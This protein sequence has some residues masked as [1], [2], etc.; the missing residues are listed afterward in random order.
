[1]SK[2]T[3]TDEQQAIIQ[4][5]KLSD[6]LLCN[7]YAGAAKTSTLEMAAPQIRVP[8][9]ALA[10]NKKNAQTMKGRL[11]SNFQTLTMNGLGQMAWARALPAHVALKLDERKLGK[12][13]TALAHDQHIELSETQW[14][15]V[16]V[17]VTLAMLEGIVPGDEGQPLV[18]D[19]PEVWQQL[20]ARAYATSDDSQ[21]LCDLARS[22]LAED[23]RLARQGHISFD[24]QVYCPTMLGGKWPRFPAAIVDEFQDLSRLN[25]RMLELSVRPDA[26]LLIVGDE[27]QSLYAFRG[28]SGQAKQLAHALRPHEWLELPLSMTFRCPKAIVARQQLHAPGFRAHETNRQGRHVVLGHNVDALGWTWK[29]LRGLREGSVAILCRNNAPLLRL[30]LQLIRQQVAPMMLGRDIGKGLA[31]LAK[32]IIPRGASGQDAL[33]GAVHEWKDKE[34]AAAE[35]EPQVD[36]ITDRAE[37]LLAVIEGSAARSQREIMNALDLLF[38]NTDGDVTLATIHRAKGLEWDVVLHLDPWRIPARAAREAH[39]RGDPVQMQQELNARYVCE[40]RTRDVLVEA[41]AEGF[42]PGALT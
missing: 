42:M 33:L 38:S 4:A 10:F 23:I 37:C 40:T 5:A 3:P 16:R 27:R 15:Q 35:T 7:A 11:P 17:M 12:L 26:K 8:A 31:A 24:D 14:A 9:L 28:A 18:R 2:L 25:F 20:A 29:Q 34:L 30:A 39:K 1:M 22:V 36:S 13:I 21:L 6:P 19:E 41:D 32:S